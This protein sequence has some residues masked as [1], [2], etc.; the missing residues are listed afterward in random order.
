MR[1]VRQ[2]GQTI[3]VVAVTVYGTSAVVAGDK[4]SLCYKWRID[5]EKE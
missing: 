3:V 2:L 4:P 5:V 1:A